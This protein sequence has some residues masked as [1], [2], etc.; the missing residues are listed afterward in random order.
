MVITTNASPSQDLAVVAVAAVVAGGP[1]SPDIDQYW[2]LPGKPF[3]H[4]MITHWWGTV[5]AALGLLWLALPGW[6]VAA[7]GAGW[8]SHLL[9]DFCFGRAAPRAG[10][11]AGVPLLPWWGHVG[12]LGSRGGLRS[13]GMVATAV[14]WIVIPL[15]LFLVA[16]VRIL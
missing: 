1:L 9:G 7:V 14:E 8:I 13:D 11:G 12:L 10:R 6:A 3:R 15:A 2:H 16:A 5:L 4:R